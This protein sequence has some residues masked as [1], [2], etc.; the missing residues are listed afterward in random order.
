MS[1][2]TTENKA[3]GMLRCLLLGGELDL[4]GL[5][6]ISLNEDKQTCVRMTSSVRGEVLMAYGMTIA[7]LIECAEEMPD[8]KFVE[9]ALF[10]GMNEPCAT[11][12]E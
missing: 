10:N 9:I 5:G 12:R 2:L 1:K 8:E 3:V 11:P 7:N 4:P 6:P